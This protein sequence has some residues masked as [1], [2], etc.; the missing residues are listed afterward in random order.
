MTHQQVNGTREIR[1]PR[2][3]TLS[4]ARLGSGPIR[5]RRDQVIGVL[6][7]GLLEKAHASVCDRVIVRRH[8]GTIS[9]ESQAGKGS[10]FV[11]R[12]PVAEGSETG[13]GA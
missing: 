8:Q 7:A 6:Y 11:I 1:P 4:A 5:K 2:I 10:T 3:D 9:V 13:A 12:L